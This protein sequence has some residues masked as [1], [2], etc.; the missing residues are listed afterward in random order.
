MTYL[1]PRMTAEI[2]ALQP[3]RWQRVRRV[4]RIVY[5]DAHPALWAALVVVAIW[6]AL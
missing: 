4:A 2:R 5:Q 3:T 6:W 1:S